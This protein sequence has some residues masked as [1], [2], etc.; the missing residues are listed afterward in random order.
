MAHPRKQSP[1]TPRP[2]GPGPVS[3]SQ[4]AAKVVPLG[5]Q[6]AAEEAVYHAPSLPEWTCGHCGTRNEGHARHCADC[7][8]PLPV[9]ALFTARTQ[10]QPG[11][12]R[13]RLKW[14]IF[15]SETI[16]LEPGH[17]SLPPKGYMDLDPEFEPARAF[18]LIA[19]NQAGTTRL[20]AQVTEV[21]PR[22][23]RFH[24]TETILQLGYPVILSWEVE[25]AQQ[26]SIS[27]DLG[28]VSD[29]SYCE[30]FFAADTTCVLTATNPLGTVTATLKLHLPPP[31][32]QSFHANTEQIRL[33]EPVILF[34]EATNAAR[35]WITDDH[36]H[37]FESDHP[38]SMTVYPDRTTTYTLWVENASGQCQRQVTLTLPAPLI[39]V[40]KADTPVSTEGEAIELYWETENAH[41]VQLTPGPGTVASRGRFKVKPRQARTLYTLTALGHEGEATATFE[42]LRFGLPL[43]ESLFAPSPL[44]DLPMDQQTA[45]TDPFTTD[46]EAME[47]ALKAQTQAQFREI[48]IQKARERQLTEDLL[49]L[50]RA[51]VRHE[52]RRAVRR[53]KDKLL[54]KK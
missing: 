6:T 29:T 18:T 3:L 48:D 25:N 15:E 1:L 19:S 13:I 45:K 37:V 2:Q 39:R 12:S 54:G 46:L 44:S 27:P 34:W 47:K 43:D 24:T 10:Y 32:I 16:Y 26:I 14:E 36:D 7:A 23:R 50:E 53:L 22:I 30:A 17:T 4:P 52:L 51:Q 28:D 41:T 11:G 35:V 8:A 33:G 9:I 49:K 5:Q 20:A 38:G 31:V 42:V 40:F 21:M